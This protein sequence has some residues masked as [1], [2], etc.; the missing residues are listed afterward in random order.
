W[1]SDKK[2]ERYSEVLSHLLAHAYGRVYYRLDNWYRM[3]ALV[4][5]SKSSL[6]AW[7]KAVGLLQTERHKV[8]FSLRNK[9]KTIFSIIWL[10]LNYRSGNR[11][12]FK[13]FAENYAFMQ[14]YEQHRGN[15]KSL[16]QHYEQ[17]SQAL[18]KP[19][20]LT[21]VNDFLAFKA[22]SWLQALVKRF[23]ISD[24]EEFANDLLCGMGGL[25]SEEAILNVLR[26]KDQIL[27]TAALNALF[28]QDAGQVLNALDEIPF[29]VFKEE[30]DIHLQRF[31]DRTLA[32]LK[33]ETPSMRSNPILL[34]RLLQNQLSSKVRLTEF[35]ERQTQIS[36][37][38][39]AKLMRKLPWRSPQRWL[40]QIV[41]KMAAYGLKSRENMRL[42]RTRGYG[43]VKDIFLAI[44]DCM[45]KEGHIA[46]REDI[47]YL[48][49]AELE[50]F[51]EG[52]ERSAKQAEIQS[53]KAQYEEYAKLSLPDRIIYEGQA[54]PKFTAPG[55]A[56]TPLAGIHQGLAVS[57]GS[58]EAEAIVITEPS[59]DIAVQGK[60]LVSRM[61]DPAWVFLMTQAAGLISE[62]GSLLS[63]TAIVGR[64]LGIPVVVG[65]PAATQIFKNGDRLR[66]NGSEGTVEILKP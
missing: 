10:V 42:C 13:L 61:T 25:E 32:E 16:W 8:N 54:F 24:K 52:D 1:V 34:L 30:F 19:W 47:F 29:T 26:L 35:I 58:V 65:I 31:G 43:A 18:F 3:M 44:G 59:L 48:D 41:W 46:E 9:L 17:S 27:D 39:K 53:R 45:Q 15:A 51:C 57:K 63:H 12:F 2:I 49:L 36:H 6:D 56:I 4:Y 22:F 50:A 28:Q 23:G 11:R 5:S 38:A 7:E 33:L 21:L 14:Q 55:T 62:K 60:I 20:Y 66:L 64:E 40:F 37:Q